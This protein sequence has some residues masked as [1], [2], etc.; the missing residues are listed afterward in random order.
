[1][2]FSRDTSPEARRILIELLRK[3]TPA[4]KLAMVG[5]LAATARE[6]AL[7]GLRMRHPEADAE[8]LETRYW[9][10]V[11][12]P[13]SADRALE[14]RRSRASGGPAEADDRRPD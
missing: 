5:G 1:M 11:L 7:A 3:K 14:A 6:F 2:L 12:G 8:E 13:E 4:E 10:L 9:R